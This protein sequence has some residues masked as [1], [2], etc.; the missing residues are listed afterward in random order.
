MLNIIDPLTNNTYSLLSKLGK[1]TLKKY[2]MQ[3][4]N[5]GS[6]E[7]TTLNI[8]FRELKEDINKIVRTPYRRQN[9]LTHLHI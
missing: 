7:E 3:F 6:M 2:I 9:T 5:G 4:Q 8:D 1:E